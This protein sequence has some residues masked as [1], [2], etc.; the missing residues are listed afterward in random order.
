MRPL[1]NAGGSNDDDGIIS[2]RLLV[3]L[4]GECSHLGYWSHVSHSTFYCF[5][6]AACGVSRDTNVTSDIFL[7]VIV[8]WLSQIN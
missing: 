5:L 8:I 2:S 7:T 3:G 1:Y 6:F 4:L